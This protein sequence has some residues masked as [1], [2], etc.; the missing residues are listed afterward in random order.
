MPTEY[1]KSL[2]DELRVDENG[3]TRPYQEDMTF[4]LT[5]RV[6][7]FDYYLLDCLSAAVGLTREEFAVQLL[8]AALLDAEQHD[9]GLSLAY[10][11]A[12][13]DEYIEALEV[14]GAY[15]ARLKAIRANWRAL[16]E[17]NRPIFK[18]ESPA[19]QPFHLAGLAVHSPKDEGEGQEV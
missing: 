11:Q 13:A 14:S 6:G 15:D 19:H 3:A 18:S 12:E 5:L 4:K 9:L 17:A 2:L 8:D 10:D 7:A 16:F 1:L